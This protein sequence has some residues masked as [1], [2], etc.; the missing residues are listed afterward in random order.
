LYVIF[1]RFFFILKTWTIGSNV[2][3]SHLMWENVFVESTAIAVT[4]MV[5]KIRVEGMLL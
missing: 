4:I 5:Q 1:S 2:W 3:F